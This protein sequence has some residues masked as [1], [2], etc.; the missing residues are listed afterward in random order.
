MKRGCEN[1]VAHTVESTIPELGLRE[2]LSRSGFELDFIDPSLRAV[3]SVMLFTRLEQ[4]LLVLD[5]LPSLLQT[6]VN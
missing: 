3:I 2:Q 4:L 5:Q 6:A 1:D